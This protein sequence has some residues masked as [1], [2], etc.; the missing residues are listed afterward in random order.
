MSNISDSDQALNDF[1]SLL[2][3]ISDTPALFKKLRVRDRAN[4]WF[5]H[6]LSEKLQERNL[7]WATAR[8]TDSTYDWQ[9]FRRMRNRCLSMIR[10]AKSTYF[11]NCASENGGNS[12]AVW[13]VVKSQTKL[14]P[15]NTPAGYNSLSITDKMDIC[16]AF[17]NHFASAGHL[18][19]KIASEN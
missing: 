13:K 18:F 7:A 3:S 15:L 9:S 8:L 17:K 4:P 10:K 1:T 11:L 12:A 14:H 19:H 16:S 6:E 5:T 2:N